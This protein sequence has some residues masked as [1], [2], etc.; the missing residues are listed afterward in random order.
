MLGPVELLDDAGGMVEL[1]GAKMRGLLA[2]LAVEAGRTV[3]PQR[4][5]DVLWGEQ[6][7]H[8]PNVV[9]GVVSKLRKAAAADASSLVVTRPAGYELA[10][11]REQIDLHRFEQLV[12]RASASPPE[13]A[14]DLLCA[15]LALWRGVPLGGAPDT[16]MIDAIRAR[17]SE[18][19]ESARD[20]LTEVQ[21]ALG[22]HHRLVGDLEALIVDD[23]LRERRWA[24]L[25][26]AL[27]G[28]GRQ[29]D[30]MRAFQRARAV[31]VDTIGAEPGPELRRLEA[32]VLAHDDEVL[33]GTVVTSGQPIGEGFR[34]T[35]NMRHATGPCVGR[36]AE[37]RRVVDQLEEYRCVT[38]TGTGGV[39]KTR[40]ALEVCARAQ[41]RMADGV[42]WTDLRSAHSAVEVMTAVQRGLQLEP[43][44]N[45]VHEMIR[46]VATVLSDRDLLLVL[47]NCEQVVEDVAMV[48]GELVPRCAGLRVLAT[49]RESLGILSERIV[50]VEPLSTDAAHELF[51]MHLDG[52]GADE[53]A[54][55]DLIDRICTR[56]DRLPLAL[57]LAAARA[58]HLR[59]DEIL[60][61]L[62]DQDGLPAGRSQSS[63][64]HDLHAVADWS[65]Q[66]LDERERRVFERLS[67]FADGATVDAA[68]SVC[69]GPEMLDVEPCLYRLVDKSLVV[70]DRS[71]AQ[72]R[73]RMLQTLADYAA[74]RLR[75]GGGE[76]GA[77]AA[78]A[79]WVA[80]LAGSVR[81][82]A[83]TTGASVAAVEDEHV[84]VRDAVQWAT[85]H[86]SPL[87]LDICDSMAAFWFGSMRVSEGFALLSGAL[88]AAVEPSEELRA[89]ALGWLGLF[90][91][92]E[93]DPELA[94]TSFAEA[95]R[96][97]HAGADRR[98]LGRLNLMLALAAGYAFD[99]R[100]PQWV[101]EARAFFTAAGDRSGA[102]HVDFAEGAVGLVVGDTER[103]ATCLRAAIDGFHHH[104]DHLGLI[105]AVSR[106]GE[107]A[108]RLHDIDLYAEMH[109]Q[110]RDLGLAGRN[111]GVTAGATARLAHA[112]LIEGDVGEA[113]R[114][115]RAA[116]ASSGSGFMPVVDG[117]VHRTA[118]LVNV[119]LGHVAEGRDQLRAAVE[120]FEHGAGGVGAGQAAL[121]WIDLGTSLIDHG[122][123]TA[124]VDA[125]RSAVDAAQR[126]GDPWIIG[127][128]AAFAG[129]PALAG[130]PGT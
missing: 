38:L 81:F 106:L 46:A 59:L 119:A 15:A 71:A 8:G 98:R 58:R 39:G 103:A 42:W 60:H 22:Q 125:C 7:V 56:L 28:A 82:G 108:Y 2:V 68:R 11:A 70:A 109:T 48:V 97:E 111:S 120:A 14:A 10:V 94:A 87:A 27:Y 105:L 64:Q 100:W 9:Q 113:E 116:L 35:G 26:R 129:L 4:L 83:V 34:R 5:I 1:S 24:Q 104:H 92:V 88:A 62:E 74:A 37:L 16:G 122:E 32:A 33:I 30:A 95:R 3:T 18:M 63:R 53:G 73:F 75:D 76:Q 89:S 31:L 96:L 90:A 115:A 51:T 128:A 13:Q 65:Y 114:L 110:L 84:A 45:D 67:V 80:G 78:H 55:A 99:D 79:E 121:C 107:L 124:A 102:A 6:E 61:R 86:H 77:R 57:E 66:L 101:A 41:G 123:I 29:A 130:T 91:T 72:T 126:S 21:L 54:D 69:A 12:D 127:Q 52:T 47:D 43:R 44:G 118:G 93:Q 85:A 23:P 117:Y 20:Q 19:R 40:L 112:R 17:L 25:M 49:S 36:H 50:H